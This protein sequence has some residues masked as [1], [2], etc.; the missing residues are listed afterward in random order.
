[1]RGERVAPVRAGR[2]SGVEYTRADAV[3]ERLQAVFDSCAVDDAATVETIRSVYAASAYLLDPES[4]IRWV[5]NNKRVFVL[6]EELGTKP[7]FFYFF[8]A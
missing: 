6:K 8:D 5:L 3:F 4:D 2:A 7:R 1:M